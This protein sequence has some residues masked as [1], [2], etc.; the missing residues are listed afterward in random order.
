MRVFLSLLG[1]GTLVFI[2]AAFIEIEWLEITT[3]RLAW[4][5]LQQPIK[6]LHVSDLHFRKVE[7]RLDRT[8]LAAM[9][10]LKPDLIV[11]TGDSLDKRSSATSVRDF[12]SQLKAPL[13]VW[14][15]PGNW[16]YWSEMKTQGDNRLPGVL[17][18]LSNIKLLQ[19]EAVP[20]AENL[21]LVG[22]DD[23]IAGQPD[24]A[25]GWS[26]VP[27]AAGVIGLLHA[28]EG[29]RHFT[30]PRAR[31]LLAGHT[32]GGQVRLPFF[33]PLWL[34]PGSGSFVQGWYD[35]RQGTRLYVN[36]GIGNSLWDIRFLC[37]PEIAVFELDP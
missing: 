24:Q 18:G 8:I 1:T 2:Y 29:V 3:H 16:D 20:I 31:L 22:M 13:G 23:E 15:V 34:P 19:N 17:D 35:L 26:K 37:R 30:D 36:R 33:G 21:W 7:R 5:G 4:D 27:S 28:P 6:I 11:I 14:V 25:K 9:A 10:S 32:H 12:F